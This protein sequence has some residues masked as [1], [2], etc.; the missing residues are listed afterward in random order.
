M[1]RIWKRLTAGILAMVLLLAMMPVQALAALTDNS[2]DRNA[3]IL[4]DLTAFLGD[5]KTAR[6][7]VELLRQ[8]GLIDKSG[9][10]LTDW[11]GAITIEESPRALTFDEAKALTG[12]TVT[13]NGRACDAAALR[14]A[15]GKLDALGLFIGGAPAA[16]WQLAV[17]GVPTALAGLPAA[18]AGA[19][20][21]LGAPAE[22]GA[23]SEVITFLAQYDLLTDTG[24]LADWRLTLPGGSRQTTMAELLVML[25]D[26]A[27]DRS[28]VVTVD[29]TP[30][31][32][33]DFETMMQIEKELT[34]IR[35]TYLQED[36]DLTA[37]QA[38]S[39]YSLYEQIAADGLTLYSTQG[40]DALVFPSGV[41]QNARI[42]MRVSSASSSTA[43]ETIT[44]TFTLNNNQ[45]VRQDISFRVRTLDGSARAGTH[46]TAYDGEV[47]I[48]AGQTE[49]SVSIQL[50]NFTP[51]WS[52]G[53]VWSGE[54]VFYIQAYQPSGALFE[55]NASSTTSLTQKIALNS[56]LSFPTSISKGGLDSADSTAKTVSFNEGE[57]YMMEHV[58]SHMNIS[59]SPNF[60]YNNNGFGTYFYTY[61]SGDKRYTAYATMY[62]RLWAGGSTLMDV[63]RGYT[64][65]R[66]PAVGWNRVALRSNGIITTQVLRIRRT[67]ALA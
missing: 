12:G 23:L 46:Y 7:A 35:D 9:N 16:D 33:G 26:D 17:D 66:C 34:R 14:D 56:S 24:A 51:S 65:G 67:D 8:Y 53:D 29:G 30:I 62:A 32:L 43:N 50:S 25:E 52:S 41:D 42:S 40:A 5:D 13:V 27:A 38:S 10:V 28:M 20:T 58:M 2:S 64:G 63:T 44:A 1:K 11:S 22:V 57:K 60:S 18:P 3:A 36:V 15:L 21:V 31:T 4:S 19:V 45:A 48:P 47:K 6:Q 55:G 61:K 49:A 39:L 59:V 37:A 54:R